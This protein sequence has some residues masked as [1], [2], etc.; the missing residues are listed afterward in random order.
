MPTLRA[1]FAEL[2]I[3]NKWGRGTGCFGD[4]NGE[5][6]LLHRC[7]LNLTGEALSVLNPID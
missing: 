1:R 7:L 6:R 3:E 5:S 4:Q 2:D